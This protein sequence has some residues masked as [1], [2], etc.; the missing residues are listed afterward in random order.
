MI[1][2]LS[3]VTPFCLCACWK[4]K[5]FAQ[6]GYCPLGFDQWSHFHN[7]MFRACLVILYNNLR[8]IK[9]SQHTPLHLTPTHTHETTYK[10]QQHAV[11]FTLNLTQHSNPNFT[12]KFSTRRVCLQ[13]AYPK[14]TWS[15][16][17]AL[18]DLPILASNASYIISHKNES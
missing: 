8:C 6:R 18:I 13:Q 4:A 17:L 11:Q 7:H 1:I 14:N 12:H 16:L 10:L 9:K 5:L 15:L 3:L 2:P